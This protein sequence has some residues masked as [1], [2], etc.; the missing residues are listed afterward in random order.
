MLKM[1]AMSTTTQGQ[2][3]FDKFE[4][5]KPAP[6]VEQKATLSVE[7]TKP[8]AVETKPA[9][10]TQNPKPIT[11]F[12][13]IRRIKHIE[14]YVA[15]LVVII[16][17]AIYASNFLGGSSQG[18]G[19]YMQQIHRNNQQ[20]AREMESNLVN[21]LSNVRGAGN[22]SAMVTV[23]GSATLEIAYN[24]DERTVTQGGPNG[25]SN[26]T[27]TIV[28]TPVIVQGPHGPQPLVLMEIKPRVTGVV[29]VA[30]GAHDIGVRLQLLR[31][32]QALV[33]CTEVNIEILSGR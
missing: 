6:I 29:I 17:I 23:V 27:V 9:P 24:I 22:V 28:K 26:T 7:P 11:L 19:G 18:S 4:P 5:I 13:R 15:G 21:T 12:Q 20:F 14:M 33:G 1:D 30:S 31:A 2:S 3:R 32:V 10:V 16:M 8:P 25:T